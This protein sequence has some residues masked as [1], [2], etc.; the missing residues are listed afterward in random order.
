MPPKMKKKIAV[1]RYNVP[2]FLW[3]TVVSQSMMP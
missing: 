3:S 2:I 1:L